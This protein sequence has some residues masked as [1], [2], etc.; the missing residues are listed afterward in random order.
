MMLKYRRMATKSLVLEA[1]RQSGGPN[2]YEGDLLVRA[3]ATLMLQIREGSKKKFDQTQTFG[4]QIDPQGR[5]T[6][7]KEAGLS[8]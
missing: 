6:G 1:M 2:N 5:S 3:V 7:P 8:D 4:N